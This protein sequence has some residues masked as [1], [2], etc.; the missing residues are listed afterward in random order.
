MGGMRGRG[1][2]GGRHERRGE[3]T[4]DGSDGLDGSF[5]HARG[6]EPSATRRRRAARVLIPFI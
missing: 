6:D 2:M 5:H 4:A 3:P 1:I